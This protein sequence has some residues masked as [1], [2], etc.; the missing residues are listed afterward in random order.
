MFVVVIETPP[1]PL[2]RI[3]CTSFH[4]VEM[5]VFKII[6]SPNG[7]AEKKKSNGELCS[8]NRMNNECC[9]LDNK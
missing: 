5:K 9:L 6:H 1:P 8:Q 3:W 2:P 7:E 4:T